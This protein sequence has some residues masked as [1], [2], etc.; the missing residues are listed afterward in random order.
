MD[1]EDREYEGLK[2]QKETHTSRGSF[3]KGMIIGILSTLVLG[4]AVFLSFGL[5][6]SQIGITPD[7]GEENVKTVLSENVQ[8]KINE[9]MGYINLY[10]FKK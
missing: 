7:G 9:L 5:V 6:K 3:V 4:A 8:N 2:A 1:L 10:F